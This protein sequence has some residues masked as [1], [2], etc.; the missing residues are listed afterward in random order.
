MQTTEEKPQAERDYSVKA[1]LMAEKD[2]EM[3]LIEIERLRAALLN[4]IREDNGCTPDDRI[5]PDC[6]GWDAQKCGCAV[7][8]RNAL[9][10]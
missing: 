7:E 6:T 10:Q 9:G 4:R 3:A 5:T 2:L 1:R 8:A